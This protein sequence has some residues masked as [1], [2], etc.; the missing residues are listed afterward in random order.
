MEAGSSGLRGDGKFSEDWRQ[1]Y[2][3]FA[4]DTSDARNMLRDIEEGL[5]YY[6]SVWSN[7]KPLDTQDLK[8]TQELQLSK[9]S[10][11]AVDLRVAVYNLDFLLR[12]GLVRSI[13]LL[14]AFIGAMNRNDFE[15]VPFLLR[16]LIE[17]AAFTLHAAKTV[18][19]ALDAFRTNA[20]GGERIFSE[21]LAKLLLGARANMSAVNQEYLGY[22]EANKG[23]N[24][25]FSELFIV[26]ELIERGDFGE[27]RKSP[28]PAY[29]RADSV[30]EMVD[31]LAAE[32]WINGAPKYA[33]RGVWEYLSGYCHPGAF[34][35]QLHLAEAHSGGGCLSPEEQMTKLSYERTLAL[36]RYILI[37]SWVVPLQSGSLKELFELESEMAREE[38]ALSSGP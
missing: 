19:K 35:W 27:K 26:Q 20:P 13:H 17:Q 37:A 7:V 38:E 1:L 18:R 36:Q 16:A 12:T 30:A 5:A 2:D 9:A 10:T 31:T 11:P 8:R 34:V 25:D 32:S 29:L 33:I 3:E 21:A 6:E 28:K 23:I 14:R 4:G 22:D 15:S 24:R